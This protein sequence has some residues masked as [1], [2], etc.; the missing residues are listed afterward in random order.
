MPNFAW[1]D[2]HGRLSLSQFTLKCIRYITI[3]WPGTYLFTRISLEPLIRTYSHTFSLFIDTNHLIFRYASFQLTRNTKKHSY[4]DCVYTLIQVLSLWLYCWKL[5]LANI[6]LWKFA[7]NWEIQIFWWIKK[8]NEAHDV[9][10]L[11]AA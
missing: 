10:C 11:K 8:W 7:K 4:H 1:F 2:N 6:K 3:T 9:I 5:M